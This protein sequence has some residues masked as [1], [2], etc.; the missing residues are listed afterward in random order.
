MSMRPEY[1]RAWYA[2]T[3]NRR[4]EIARESKRRVGARRALLQLLTDLPAAFRRAHQ[5]ETDQW[6][7]R[8]STRCA[9]SAPAPFWTKPP[10]LSLKSSSQF[11]RPEKPARSPSLST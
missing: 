2:R 11:S 4:R 10:V 8:Y 9:R 3:I 7:E 5:L 6:L 1:A